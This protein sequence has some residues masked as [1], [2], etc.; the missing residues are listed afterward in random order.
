MTIC[1]TCQ[2]IRDSWLLPISP[3]R[4]AAY[5]ERGVQPITNRWMHQGVGVT[6]SVSTYQDKLRDY[7]A[8]RRRQIERIEQHCLEHH[9]ETIA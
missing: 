2:P 5:A 7:S 3:E 9:R 6:A 8:L 1:P 4:L